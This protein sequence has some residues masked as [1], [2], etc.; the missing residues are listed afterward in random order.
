MTSPSQA[1][2]WKHRNPS[3]ALITV[4]EAALLSYG[5]QHSVL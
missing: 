4:Q 3:S 2:F 1:G 5:L